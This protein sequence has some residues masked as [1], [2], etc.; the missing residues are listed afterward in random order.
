MCKSFPKVH[1]NN[2]LDLL[3][4]INKRSSL[5]NEVSLQ[6][7]LEL[8]LLVSFHKMTSSKFGSFACAFH[9]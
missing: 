4:R 5:D 6:K 3:L 2:F 8:Q 7:A 9:Y 1:K